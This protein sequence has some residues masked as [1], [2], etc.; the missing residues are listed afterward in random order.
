MKKEHKQVTKDQK[1][2]YRDP[3]FDFMHFADQ[4]YMFVSIAT[5]NCYARYTV[6]FALLTNYL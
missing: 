6:V 2:H 3:Y 5:D 4:L 1:A